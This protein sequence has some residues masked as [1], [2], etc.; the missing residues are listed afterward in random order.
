MVAA[1]GAGFQHGYNTGVV[2]APQNVIEKWMSDVSQERHG[3]PPDKNDITFLF[4]LA[5]SIYCAGGIV[6]GLLTSTFA[7]HIGRRG[8][9]FV[10]NLFALIAAAMMGLS[11][12]AGSFELLIAGRC[13]SGLNSGLNSGLAG[14]YLVEVSPRSM[15]GAL[16]SMYQLI[17]TISILVSQ[18]LGSQSIFGTDDLWPVLF[19]LTGIMALAQMLFLPCCPETPK[20]IFNKGNKERAQKSLKWL[21]KREDV[22]AEMSEI[23]TEAEQE[24]SIGKASFQQFIQNPSLRKPLIIAIVIMIAQQ[25]SGINA[26]IYYSTQIFQKAGMSQQEAQLA[27]M[28]MG[29]VNIIMTVI[30]VFLV[31]IAGRKTLLLIGF[32]LMFIVTALL[33]VLLEFIQYDF[34]SYMCVALVVLF[35]VC[36]ATGPGSIPWFLVA[37]LFGQDARPLAASISIGCNWTANFLVGLFFLPLQELIGPKVFIIFAVLQLIFTIFIFFK[38]PETK[39]KSL[40]EVLKYFK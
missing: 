38:V 28:I 17:I 31:E 29:T 27:T 12:M 3:M 21:R 6:G 10:N 33:A 13:F 23:Q 9:L 40:D 39:N 4:S 20:H 18:I 36:F 37:E 19:G 16:G 22:S 35:I 11:K 32:G 1:I 2:N 30:S 5:V 24:K 8:G 34:A 7:I 25:L 14:M 26:V 15:R